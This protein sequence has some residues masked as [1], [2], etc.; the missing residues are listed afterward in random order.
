M[1]GIIQNNQT[2]HDTSFARTTCDVTIAL[3]IPRRFRRSP[4]LRICDGR[5][6]INL[7]GKNTAY[8]LGLLPARVQ[9]LKIFL[10]LAVV[11]WCG[12]FLLVCGG[13]CRLVV[14]GCFV[15]GAVDGFFAPRVL[16]CRR[17]L[18]VLFLCRCCRW[19]F[20]KSVV[21]FV[22]EIPDFF[23]TACFGRLGGCVFWAFG[24]AVRLKLLGRRRM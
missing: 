7:N 4:I 2:E 20:C 23:G 11:G 15:D 9:R 12:G 13:L 8:L 10:A 19:G 1:Q 16:F 3:T 21:S 14:R 22:G 6:R 5:N 24:L 18:L 17:L